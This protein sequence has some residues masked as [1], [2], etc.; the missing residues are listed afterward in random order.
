M[1]ALLSFELL[2]LR[3]Q[4]SIYICAGIMVALL[5]INVITMY[6]V[7]MLSDVFAS[8]EGDAMTEAEKDLLFSMFSLN[9]VSTVLTAAANGSYTI[10]AGIVTVLFVCCDYSQ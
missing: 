3:K 9:V 4:K 7:A 6:G 2:K 1:K 5:F 10:I 8:V